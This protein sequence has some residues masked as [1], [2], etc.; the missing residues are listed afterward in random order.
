MNS[1]SLWDELI[2]ME[3]EEEEGGS[4]GRTVE[5]ND[6]RERRDSRAC[7]GGEEGEMKLSRIGRLLIWD[8]EERRRWPRVFSSARLYVLSLFLCFLDRIDDMAILTDRA[9]LSG[10]LVFAVLNQMRM[11][12]T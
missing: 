7:W 3:E 9:A 8:L 6:C 1:G 4:W 5:K 12:E 11:R 2:I 10:R